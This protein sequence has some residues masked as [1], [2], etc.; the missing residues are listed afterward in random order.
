M[1]YSVDKQE[2]YSLISLNEEKVDSSLAPEIKSKFI[3]W[4]AEGLKNMVLDVSGVK[5]MDS[6]GLSTL[7]IANRLCNDESGLF[8]LVGP[9]DHVLKLIKIS[10]LDKVLNILPT[11]EEGIDAVFMNELEKDLKSGEG[12]GQE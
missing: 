5:Y 12:T 2:K 9:V 3:T 6:S 8:V 4:H 7:L 10:Q 1:K 11:V